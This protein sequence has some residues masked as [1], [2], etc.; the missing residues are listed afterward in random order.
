[1]ANTRQPL[2]PSVNSPAHDES[3]PVLSADG[4]QL[5]FWSLS[6]DDSYG[7]HDIYLSESG[8]DGAWQPAVHL[9]YPLNDAACNMAFALS[10]D[11]TRLL[12]YREQARAGGTERGVDLALAERGPGF[13]LAPTAIRIEGYENRGQASLSATLAA[14]SRTLLLSIEGPGTLGGDDLYVC[15]YDRARRRFSAPRN[16]GPLLNSAGPE[17]TPY[18]ASDGVTLYFSAVRPGGRGGLDVWMTRRLDESWTRWTPPQNLGPAVNSPG[19]DLYLRLP[20]EGAEAILASN[21]D[22]RAATPTRDLYRVVLTPELRPRPVLLVRGRVRDQRTN[23]PIRASVLYQALP[24][25]EELGTAQTD[26]STLE[27]RMILPAG[28]SYG[29]LALAPGYV[30]VAENLAV[31]LPPGKAFAE[32]ERDLL[33][34]PLE[35]GSIIRLNN[36]FFD[37]GRAELRPASRPELDRLVALLRSEVRLSLEL[38]GHTD[39]V[40]PDSLNRDLSA[41]RAQA[42]QAYL[43]S[44]GIEAWRTVVRG[45]GASVPLAG[46]ATEADRQRNRRVEIRILS[47]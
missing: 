1:M 24:S 23:Q 27:Y 22:G 36:L 42:V 46:N 16:L 4:Q 18:L 32:L 44:Q 20:A 25:G 12:V 3:A 45:Y 5:Y 39:A 38:A 21:H 9:D 41:R 8:P 19:D 17:V 26:T 29:F 6:R 13:W 2:G 7:I 47:L 30:A 14:D 10:P 34:A 33:L 15:F 35:V 40:G 43:A 31:T 28:Q 11:G 37:T